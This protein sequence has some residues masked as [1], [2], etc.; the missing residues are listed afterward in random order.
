MK[1]RRLISALLCLL[2]TSAAALPISAAGTGNTAN[3]AATAAET[4]IEKA[5]TAF[6]QLLD[7]CASNFDTS[8]WRF[9]F[10]FIRRVR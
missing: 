4:R 8:T 3:T 1:T 7:K 2:M 5:K 10:A 6:R 9:D